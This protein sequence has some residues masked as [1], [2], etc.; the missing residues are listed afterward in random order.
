LAQYVEKIRTR[1][2]NAKFVI[3]VWIEIGRAFW[4]SASMTHKFPKIAQIWTPTNFSQ[5]FHKHDFTWA[6]PTSFAQA[7]CLIL[8]RKIKATKTPN[9][10]GYN[11]CSFKD[12]DGSKQKPL[13]FQNEILRTKHFKN[14][15]EFFG[16]F[17]LTKSGLYPIRKFS[18]SKT[19]NF[20]YFIKHKKSTL[21]QQVQRQ[22]QTLDF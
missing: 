16:Y 21:C 14:I 1:R 4:L 20:L 17:L 10:P 15:Q 18:I 12:K 11:F 19:L 22:P 9:L 7:V 8:V 5:I 2:K 3:F 13:F 6:K